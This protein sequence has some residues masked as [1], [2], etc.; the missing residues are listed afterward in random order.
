MVYDAEM[1]S[2]EDFMPLRLV[3][4]NAAHSIRYVKNNITMPPSRRSFFRVKGPLGILFVESPF[5]IGLL[6]IEGLRSITINCLRL[7][8]LLLPMTG[9]NIDH[10]RCPR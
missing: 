8:Q 6:M 2:A 7:M 4:R 10:R 9:R 3:E 5:T 1:F